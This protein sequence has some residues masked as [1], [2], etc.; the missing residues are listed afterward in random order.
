MPVAFSPQ[1]EADLEEIGDFIA[2]DSPATAVAFIDELREQ[3]D[4]IAKT[5]TAYRRRPELGAALRSCA[6]GRYVIF[7]NATEAQ[8]RIERVLHS[9]RD[10]GPLFDA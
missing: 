4:R 10:L 6:H 3:C 9:A 1:A 5:P 8:L 7:F 2:A